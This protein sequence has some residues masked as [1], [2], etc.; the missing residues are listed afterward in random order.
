[1][2]HS[3]VNNRSRWLAR[4]SAPLAGLAL[5]A[6]GI[7]AAQAHDFDQHGHH[8]RGDVHRTMHRDHDGYRGHDRRDYRHDRSDRGHGYGW[9]GERHE[10]GR[11]DHHR[12]GYDHRYARDGW[13]HDDDR[14]LFGRW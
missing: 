12:Y 3:N 10:R 8:D 1:M 9:R 13:R 6:T 5:L 7:G 4:L 2:N 11:Y 14:S